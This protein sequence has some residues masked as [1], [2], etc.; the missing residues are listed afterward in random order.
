MGKSQGTLAELLI[1]ACVN[2]SEPTRISGGEYGRALDAARCREL[3]R[4]KWKSPRSH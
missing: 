4:S 2:L 3:I 1:Q